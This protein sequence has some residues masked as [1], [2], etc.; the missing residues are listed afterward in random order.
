MYCSQV[1]C[2]S[3]L[4]VNWIKLNSYDDDDDDDYSGNDSNND[5]DFKVI[6]R[7]L[8]FY[9]ATLF[10]WLQNLAALYQPIRNKTKPNSHLPVHVS[11]ASA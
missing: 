9:I 11:R 6:L 7:L 2:W 8:W 3:M 4:V 10:D 5:I 1:N